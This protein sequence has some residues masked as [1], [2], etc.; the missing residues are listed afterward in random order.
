MVA[1]YSSF[2]PHLFDALQKRK[3]DVHEV[4]LCRESAILESHSVSKIV[5][6]V[7]SFE[8]SLTKHQKMVEK[9]DA[10]RILSIGFVTILNNEQ[11]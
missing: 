11:G 8:N 3:S 2:L 7:F 6:I 9:I 5:I 4:H 1:K 10:T